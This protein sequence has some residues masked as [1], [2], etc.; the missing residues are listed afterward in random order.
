M[1]PGVAADHIVA[2]VAMA[3]CGEEF[4]RHANDGRLSYQH[5]RAQ[6]AAGHLR[7][8]RLELDTATQRGYRTARIDLA[9]LL[10]QPSAGTLRDDA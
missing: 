4:K 7:E 3:A 8:A 1:A 5:A 9:E 2:D 6:L 10:S